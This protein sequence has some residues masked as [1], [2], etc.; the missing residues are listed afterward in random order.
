MEEITFT[1]QTVLRAKADE[2]GF[3][4]DENEK[5]KREMER[6]R[7]EMESKRK[8]YMPME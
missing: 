1:P 7:R 8:G 3:D 2:L 4:Y 5:L 6:L